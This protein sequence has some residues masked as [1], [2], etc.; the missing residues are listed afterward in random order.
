MRRAVDRRA[1]VR[2]RH[3]AMPVALEEPADLLAQ[4]G[5]VVDD[6]DVER[7][8]GHAANASAASARPGAD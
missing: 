8:D 3:H 2:D 1:P 6:E 4:L 5:L 7:V